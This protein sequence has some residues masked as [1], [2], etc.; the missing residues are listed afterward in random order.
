MGVMNAP[1]GGIGNAPD[2]SRM[3]GSSVDISESDAPSRGEYGELA[4]QNFTSDLRRFARAGSE[5]PIAS[6]AVAY[7]IA[8]PTFYGS[9][10]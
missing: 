6:A 2:R 8:W 9:E 7:I 3:I 1:D 5:Q 10:Y 4:A